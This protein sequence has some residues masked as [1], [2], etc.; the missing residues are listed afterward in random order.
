LQPIKKD[1]KKIHIFT[2]DPAAFKQMRTDDIMAHFRNFG[3]S[4]V[5]WMGEYGCNV[6]FED[7]F[8]AS[9]ALVAMSQPIASIENMEVWDKDN[10]G[11][12]ERR[13]A[14]YLARKEEERK[15]D[16]RNRMIEGGLISGYVQ[17]EMEDP[18]DDD[19]QQEAEEERPARVDLATMGWKICNNPV[20]KVQNDRFGRKGTR[21]RFLCRFGTSYDVLT[22]RPED[23][24]K[25]RIPRG[26][27]TDRVLG[28]FTGTRRDPN[29][30]NNNNK[31]RRRDDG[32][33]DGGRDDRRE[34]GRDDRRGGG[35]RS[36]YDDR[37]GDIDAPS[38]MNTALSSERK[39]G[40][41]SVEELERER[42]EKQAMIDDGSGD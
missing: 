15:E 33:N 38:A 24:D 13:R 34:G 37:G 26:F 28:K 31:R 1:P 39:Q 22:Y 41:F 6:L 18:D 30:R 3:P 12:Y 20:W 4:Y 16:E 42:Q 2:L 7:E 29:N 36:R 10:K 14:E 27:A 25:P 35:G 17:K 23:S 19:M 21:S 11:E 5:E 9:R 8:S 40:G 32:N